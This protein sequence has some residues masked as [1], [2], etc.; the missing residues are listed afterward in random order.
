LKAAGLEA[1][2]VEEV[3]EVAVEALAVA[4]LEVAE[5]SLAALVPARVHHSVEARDLVQLLRS[6]VALALHQVHH[7]ALAADRAPLQVW[8]REVPLGSAADRAPVQGCARLDQ[9][10]LAEERGRARVSRA[11]LEMLPQPAD[12][13]HQARVSLAVSLACLR[14]KV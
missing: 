14:M 11:V 2:E 13:V 4:L 12:S 8:E 1:A 6:A 7:L 10:E 5:D 9:P 3:V